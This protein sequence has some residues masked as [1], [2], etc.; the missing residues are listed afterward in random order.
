[1][2]AVALWRIAVQ[3][4]LLTGRRLALAGALLSA[5]FAVAGPTEWLAHRWL[6]CREAQ[7]FAQHWIDAVRAQYLD[8]AYRLTTHPDFRQEP[9][10]ADGASETGA[11]TAN[12]E[13]YGQQ[14]T[15]A[16]LLKL[17]QRAE[18]RDW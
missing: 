2:S 12:R 17:G 15:V 13:E 8:L 14:P 3:G 4:L 10:G 18:Y 7:Q 6:I 16:R 9:G 5:A 11:A 1:M